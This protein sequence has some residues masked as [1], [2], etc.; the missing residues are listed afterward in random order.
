M[1]YKKEILEKL[2]NPEKSAIVE[3]IQSLHLFNCS[4]CFE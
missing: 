1:T 4:V 3:A 2:G